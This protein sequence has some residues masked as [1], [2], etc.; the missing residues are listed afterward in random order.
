MRFEEIRALNKTPYVDRYDVDG[1]ADS[2]LPSS[3]EMLSV[4]DLVDSASI[5]RFWDEGSIA[6]LPL[7]SDVVIDARNNPGAYTKPVVRHFGAHMSSFSKKRTHQLSTYSHLS[8]S[9]ALVQLDTYLHFAEESAKELDD[10]EMHQDVVD[11]YNNVG[12]LSEIDFNRGVKALAEIW[13]K[14]VNGSTDVDSGPQQR[15][16]DINVF[17]PAQED[18]NNAKS[19][20]FVYEKVIEAVGDIDADALSHIHVDQEEWS[21]NPGSLTVFVDDWVISGRSVQKQLLS[22]WSAL[23]SRGIDET[24]IEV[25]C[26][27]KDES[28]EQAE[29]VSY[30][31]IF[32]HEWSDDDHTEDDLSDPPHQVASMFGAHGSV[33]YGFD[34]VLRDIQK[35]LNAHGVYVPAPVFMNIEPIDY[36]SRRLEQGEELLESGRSIDEINREN[37]EFMMLHMGRYALER[38][39]GTMAPQTGLIAVQR[40]QRYVEVEASNLNS[41]RDRA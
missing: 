2:V 19:H 17:V 23:K 41:T 8:E 21:D 9:E 7:F 1:T 27:A 24:S 38:A 5:E 31:S 26:L 22:M 28:C 13:V 20:H 25:H 40:R 32:S 18:E 35:Q 39:G 16:V 11:L 12:Y 3:S 14:K 33:N 6:P 29:G 34:W 30:R 15:G 10:E 36:R 37:G 4:A